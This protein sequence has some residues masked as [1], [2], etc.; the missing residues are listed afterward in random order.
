MSELD[1]HNELQQ[2]SAEN[3]RLRRLAETLMDRVEQTTSAANSPFGFFQIHAALSEQLAQQQAALRD[4]R[5]T[6]A[7][8]FQAAPIGLLLFNDD[9]V[10]QS[11]NEYAASKFGRSEQEMAGQSL[12]P[13]VRCANAHAGGGGCGQTAGCTGCVLRRLLEDARH[14]GRAR[15]EH[16]LALAAESGAVG[17]SV[18]L[19]LKAERVV[20]AGNRHVLLS[21][22][23]IGNKKLAEQQLRKAKEAAE[24]ASRLKSRFL[25]NVSHEIRT[26]LNGIMGFAEAI[27]TST[28]LEAARQQ[29]QVIL[30]ESNV[31][32]MLVNDL[33]DLVKIESG[34]LVLERVPVDLCQILRE[35]S[36][37]A[38]MQAR[39]KGLGFV[40]TIA[41]DVPG[42]ILS[43]PLRLRQII[44]NLI[45]NAIK[46]TERG[47]V[48]V[49]VE[50]VPD[51]NR[52]GVRVS[53]RDTGIGIPADKQQAIFDSFTQVDVSTTRKYG[54][55]GLG[56]AIVRQLA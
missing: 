56:L 33:L 37:S 13:A 9:L 45:S 41:V 8:I 48:R 28:T 36:Q 55:T 38:G 19:R 16:E 44:L 15:C 10:I 4:G 23:D 25:S 17:G 39:A 5:Q 21:L 27:L 35:L 51:D 26:P 34:K 47:E 11:V 14:S 7:T 29:S 2:L 52:P 22:E 54:G 6:L 40:A 53:V 42:H 12:G 3:A 49:S 20:I 46:F 30:R 31:L 32:L 24:E 43:D 50:W 1:G 18:W